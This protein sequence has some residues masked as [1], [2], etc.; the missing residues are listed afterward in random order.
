MQYHI[1][2][3]PQTITS[4]LRQE[5]HEDIRHV[6][7]RALKT[8][9][10]ARTPSHYQDNLPHCPTKVKCQAEEDQGRIQLLKLN[11][12][13]DCRKQGHAHRYAMPQVCC[14]LIQVRLGLCGQQSAVLEACLEDISKQSRLHSQNLELVAQKHKHD[15][16]HKHTF[17]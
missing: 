6:M 14:G 17:G 4:D 3:V 8:W 7:S 10:T 16:M 9:H 15:G 13:F 11:L 5:V 1:C 12:A 2:E